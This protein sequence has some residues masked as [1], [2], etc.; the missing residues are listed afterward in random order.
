MDDVYIN[1]EHIDWNK[2]THQEL[3]NYKFLDKCVPKIVIRNSTSPPWIDEEVSGMYR[4][5]IK[6][7]GKAKQSNNNNNNNNN[8]FIH[9]AFV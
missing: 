8:N 3:C 5:K 1:T 6:A 9:V 2:A 4:L 7:W